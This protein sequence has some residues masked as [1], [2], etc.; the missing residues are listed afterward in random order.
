LASRSRL[1]IGDQRRPDGPG[2][3]RVWGSQGPPLGR[4]W[5]RGKKHGAVCHDGEG[6]GQQAPRLERLMAGGWGTEQGGA[7][8]GLSFSC[9]HSGGGTVHAPW[10]VSHRFQARFTHPCRSAARRDVAVVLTWACGGLAARSGRSGH[11]G[12]RGGSCCWAIAELVAL[13][14]WPPQALT[15]GSVVPSYDGSWPSFPSGPTQGSSTP[16]SARSASVPEFRS[17][18]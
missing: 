3:S 16:V 12:L 2:W 13:G 11:A 1:G 4:A 15:A 18:R 14:W 6:K 9:R 17:A 5:R 8:R 10:A 7:G